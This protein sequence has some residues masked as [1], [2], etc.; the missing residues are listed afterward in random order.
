MVSFTATDGTTFTDRNAYRKHEMETQYTYRGLTNETKIKQP[1]SCQGQPFDMIDCKGCTLVVADNTDQIQIDNCQGSKIFLAASSESLFIRD[2]SDCVIYCCVKQLR[3]RDCKN[4]EFV[5]QPSPPR[6][7]RS[8]PLTLPP[9]SLAC[10]LVQ[11]TFYLH[12]KTEPIIE[13][14]SGMNFAPFDGGYNGHAAALGR[15]N[16]IPNYNLW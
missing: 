2:C 11:G 12:C 7:P 3:T 10:S 4:C 15:A 8:N 9:H 6:P 13:T 1:D 16:L 5:S 14:S